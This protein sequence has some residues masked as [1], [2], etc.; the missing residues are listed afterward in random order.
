[1]VVREAFCRPAL[2]GAG[3]RMDLRPGCNAAEAG[4]GDEVALVALGWGTLGL[5]DEYVNDYDIH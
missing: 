4:E 2:Q 3:V 1:M 5:Y